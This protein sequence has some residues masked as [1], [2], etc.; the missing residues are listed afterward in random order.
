MEGNVFP[1][2]KDLCKGSQVTLLFTMRGL[3]CQEPGKSVPLTTAFNIVLETLDNT[4]G[5][6]IEATCTQTGKETIQ[7][8][9][10][11]IHAYLS[12]DLNGLAMVIQTTWN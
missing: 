8:F 9:D 12:R 5:H 2:I 3:L 7:P 4:T 6:E 10:H 11:R 1:L